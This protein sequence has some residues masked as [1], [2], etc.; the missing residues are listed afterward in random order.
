MGKPDV[1]W[2]REEQVKALPIPEKSKSR[3]EGLIWAHS[4][5]ILSIT[6]G[7]LKG[8]ELEASQSPSPWNSAIHI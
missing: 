2:R 6:V 8:K 1:S 3:K 4:L 5:N 7:R